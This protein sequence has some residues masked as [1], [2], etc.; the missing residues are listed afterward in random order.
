MEDVFQ[1]VNILDQKKIFFG[2]ANLKEKIKFIRPKNINNQQ[3]RIIHNSGYQRL[4]SLN[5][6]N[7]YLLVK[8]SKFRFK[9]KI[10]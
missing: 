4:S 10:N 8:N 2:K 6:N 5:G 1:V 3:N 9:T 7:K